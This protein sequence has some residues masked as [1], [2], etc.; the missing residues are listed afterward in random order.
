MKK[1]HIAAAILATSLLAVPGVMLAQQHS[2]EEL[3]IEMAST[4]AEHNAVSRHYTA[5]AQEAREDAKR[6]QGMAST[7]ASGRAGQ[8]QNLRQHC[9]ALAKKY[10]EIAVEYDALAKLHADEARGAGQ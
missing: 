7:Y 9:E 6:H 4:P 3:V 2:V 5:L 10:E 8:R 1:V